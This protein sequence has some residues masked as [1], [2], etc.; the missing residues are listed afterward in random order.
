MADVSLGQS[1]RVRRSSL[2][3]I[4]YGRPQLCIQCSVEHGISTVC[5]SVSMVHCGDTTANTKSR[6][7]QGLQL[8]F[9][10]QAGSDSLGSQRAMPASG[11]SLKITGNKLHIQVNNNQNPGQTLMVSK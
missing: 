11:A 9:C 8:A 10:R 2:G 5:R 3:D 1:V 6:K 4:S 7:T